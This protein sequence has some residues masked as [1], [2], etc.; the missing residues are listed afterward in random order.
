MFL[1]EYEYKIDAKGRVPIPPRF[2]SRFGEGIVL[3][4]DPDRCIIACP[5]SLWA[6]ITDSFSALPFTRS[7]ERRIGRFIFGNAFNLELDEQGR[8][9]LPAKLR[10][11]AGIKES[12]VVVGANKYLEIWDNGLWEKEQEDVSDQAWQILEGMERRE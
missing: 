11:Y 3:A 1:G 7:K 9:L 4:R 12:A 6:E 5:P 8:V 2:R 10:E